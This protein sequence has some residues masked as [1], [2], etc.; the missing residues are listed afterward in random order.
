MHNNF[1]RTGILAHFKAAHSVTFV[2]ELPQTATGKI[3]KYVL[4]AQRTAI[5][6]Q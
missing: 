3:Q 6:S 5:A 4:K 1:L 2:K